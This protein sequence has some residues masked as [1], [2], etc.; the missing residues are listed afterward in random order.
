MASG[1]ASNNGLVTSAS[2]N[3]FLERQSRIPTNV[4][5]AYVSARVTDSSRATGL[6]TARRYTGRIGGRYLGTEEGGRA[7]SLS[8]FLVIL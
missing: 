6:K 5:C 3:C 8:K 4:V 1:L 7:T 2:P